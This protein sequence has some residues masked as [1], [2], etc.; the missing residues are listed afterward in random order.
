MKLASKVLLLSILFVFS[1]H[2]IGD[3]ESGKSLSAP[4]VNC[5][6]AD[7]NSVAPIWPKIAG[8]HEAYLVKQLKEYRKGEEGPR[9][10][11]QMYDQVMDLSDQDILDLAAYY[12]GLEQSAGKAR[13]EIFK[14][15]ERIYRG[16]LYDKGV[17]ACAGCH[18]ARGMGNSLAGYPR[19]SGQN[20]DYTLD[21]LK[22]FG[23]GAR[24]NDVN[25]I[26]RNIS[27]RMSEQ[28]MKAVSEY[29]AGLS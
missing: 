27:A 8:Q 26:M 20:S 1:A 9:H 17:T 14:L 6:G 23:E 25:E 19:V 24:R 15:G 18:G 11:P 2:G 4:C 13:G 3:P 12:A 7:G 10:N 28:E 16:G 21:Q 22:Q 5:H 29:I